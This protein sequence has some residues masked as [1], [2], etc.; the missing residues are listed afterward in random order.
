MVPALPSIV[1]ATDLVVLQDNAEAFERPNTSSARRGA[2]QVCQ[3]VR[4]TDAVRGWV[5]V[6]LSD[7][8]N[9][10]VEEAAVRPRASST[11]QFQR[12]EPS[13]RFE[14]FATIWP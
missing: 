1:A 9:V 14:A 7:G 5:A 8:L 11:L 6:E 2:L 13:W 3:R 12:V 4:R 10:W